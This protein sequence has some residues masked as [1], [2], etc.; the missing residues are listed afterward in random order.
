M[1]LSGAEKRA[2]AR[3]GNLYAKQTEL[4]YNPP[5]FLKLNAVIN[6]AIS[7]FAWVVLDYI[8]VKSGANVAEYYAFTAVYGMVSEGK[9]V[10]QKLM[11]GIELSNVSFRYDENMP[12]VLENPL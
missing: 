10:I 3:W 7:L 4:S 5:L 8:A 11:G 6:T 1:K 9:Q 2:F 12:N